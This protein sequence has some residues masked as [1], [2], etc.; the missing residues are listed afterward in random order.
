[1]L[2]SSCKSPVARTVKLWSFH[3]RE[4]VPEPPS[5]SFRTKVVECSVQSACLASMSSYL[6][7]GD[8]KMCVVIFPSCVFVC[9]CTAVEE[10]KISCFCAR[11]LRRLP[12]KWQKASRNFPHSRSLCL[13]HFNKYFKTFLH[14]FWCEKNPK[15]LNLFKVKFP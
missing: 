14:Y 5:Y 2:K 3:P 13:H 7:G 10:D 4:P 12:N 6:P 11:Y 1:M 8:V 15:Y 9:K